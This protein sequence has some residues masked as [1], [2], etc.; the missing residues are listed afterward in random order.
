MGA[1]DSE[2]YSLGYRFEHSTPVETERDKF[3]KEFVG[4]KWSGEC[5]GFCSSTRCL[6][7][8][9]N[10][11]ESKEYFDNQIKWHNKNLE[12][13]S[14]R[15]NTVEMDRLKRRFERIFPGVVK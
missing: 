15:Q 8:P 4:P 3:H 7:C 6:P 11:R 14:R 1:F 10:T 13:W 12:F 9:S 5:V 2:L